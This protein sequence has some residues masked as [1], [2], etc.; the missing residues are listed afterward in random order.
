[1]EP[2]HHACPTWEW[3]FRRLW[4][5]QCPGCGTWWK[6]QPVHLAGWGGGWERAT[7]LSVW[8][9]VRRRRVVLGE[10]VAAP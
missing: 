8:W 7:R 10:D 9:A 6:A 3:K 5:R 1:M 4:V 2:E